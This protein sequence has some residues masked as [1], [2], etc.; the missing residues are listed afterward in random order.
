VGGDDEF[1]DFLARRKPLFRRPGDVDLEPPPELDRIVLRQA[2][3][4]IRADQPQRSF[5]GPLWG[6]PLAVAATL[7]IAFTVVLHVGMTH[8]P[9]LAEV[10]VQ[11]ISQEYEPAASPPP[12]PAAARFAEDAPPERALAARATRRDE[13]PAEEAAGSVVVDLATPAAAPPPSLAKAR[14]AQSAAAQAAPANAE[15]RR[16]ARSWLAHIER[17]RAAGRNAEA[18]AELVEY[19]RQNRA[20][21]GAPDR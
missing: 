12:A 13:T 18:D 3:D 2:E 11:N 4:A 1:D 8:K 17:L 20:Y 21:A 16:D 5:R 14:P 19:N 7:L 6:A 9:P 10:R 15:W